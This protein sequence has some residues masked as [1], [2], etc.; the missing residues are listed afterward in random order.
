ML[1]EFR[2][3]EKVIGAKQSSRA[4][5][6]GLA[7]QVFLAS[8]ADPRLTAPLLELCRQSNVPVT[9]DRSMRQLGQ[10]AGIQVGAAVVTLLRDT[11][12]P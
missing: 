11:K 6:S 4:V 3:S 12:S 7:R 10:A 9:V 2:T 8:D 1:K 5:R